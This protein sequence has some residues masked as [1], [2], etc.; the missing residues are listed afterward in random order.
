MGTTTPNI[1]I[2]LPSPGETNYQSNFDAGMINIDQHDHSGGPNKGVPIGTT[3]LSDGSVTY[4][5]LNA[6]VADNTTGIGTSLV[7]PN[8]LQI[9]GLLKNIYQL[10]TATGFITKDGS[11]AHARTF[12]NTASVL[13]TN[14]DG[15]AGNPSAALAATQQFTAL[16]IGVPPLASGITFNGVDALGAY[17]LGTFVPTITGSTGN[18]APVY[19]TQLGSYQKIGKLVFVSIQIVVSALVGGTGDFQIV[20]LPFTTDATIGSTFSGTF[21]TAGGTVTRRAIFQVNPNSTTLLMYQDD[22]GATQLPQA[23]TTAINISGCYLANS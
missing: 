14:A 16:G 20:T 1:G 11:L 18:P 15:A 7:L 5:K 8:Q 12:Q 9:L 23:T 22:A 4:N 6:N 21:S 10:V 19:V 17:T 3:G 2:Y 13:W